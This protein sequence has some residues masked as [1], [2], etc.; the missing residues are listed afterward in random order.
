MLD[1]PQ[2][3]YQKFR[4]ALAGLFIRAGGVWQGPA[5]GFIVFDD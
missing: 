5:E 2:S 1:L 3:H 4:K